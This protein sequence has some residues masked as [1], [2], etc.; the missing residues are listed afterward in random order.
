MARGVQLPIQQLPLLQCDTPKPH[1]GPAT[2]F[3]LL[4][5]FSSTSSAQ[6]TAAVAPLELGQGEV[7]DDP[8]PP[9]PELQ[10]QSFDSSSS[11][12]EPADIETARPEHPGVWVLFSLRLR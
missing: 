2:C 8:P 7:Q 1:A 9:Q 5:D 4:P 6:A 10:V 11:E 3:P 12:G